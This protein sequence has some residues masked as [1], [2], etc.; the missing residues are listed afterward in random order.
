MKRW[1]PLLLALSL[2]L[3]ACAKTEPP[4]PSGELRL[5]VMLPNLAEIVVAL[6]QGDHLVGRCAFCDVPGVPASAVDVGGALDP[7]LERLIALRPTLVLAQDSQEELC[8]R[9]TALGIPVLA[10]PLY[11]MPDTLTA[12]RT[13][14]RRIGEPEKGARLVAALQA[15]LATVRSSVDNKTPVRTLLVVGH[16]PGSLGEIFL[17][18]PRSFL[19]ELLVAAGGK[20]VVVDSSI[21]YPKYSK[22][23]ILQLNPEAI[24]VLLPDADDTPATAAAER[25]LWAELGYLQ[26]VKD[27]RVLVL[28]QDWIIT[29]GPRMGE[30][31]RVFAAALH[32]PE[33]S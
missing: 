11:T 20:N 19:H 33:D 13:I 16:E 7:D 4:P 6:G 31:A 10:V 25:A 23:A 21:P 28:T 12:M 22:E 9:L 1:L 26:A 30:I 17:A 29:P 8:T 14:A 3:G 2:A 5:V 24:L 27:D 32:P 18:G 15:Q